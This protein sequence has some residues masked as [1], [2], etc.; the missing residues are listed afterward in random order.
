MFNEILKKF[1]NLQSLTEQEEY[2]LIKE[3][4]IVIHFALKAI[5]KQ[6]LTEIYSQELFE[7]E[8]LNETIIKL[9]DKREIILTKIESSQSLKSYIKFIVVNH[10]KDK[11]KKKTIKLSQMQDS[12]I[13]YES[14]SIKPIVKMEA[15]EFTQISNSN[16]TKKEKEAICLELLRTKQ[17]GYA[18]EKAKSRAKNRLKNIAQEYEFSFD[19][20][21]FA[22]NRLFLS[23]I[24]KEFVSIKEGV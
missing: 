13:E 20:V 12:E 9:I 10:L 1:L 14:P 15:I 21:N 6:S 23:E 17:T 4:K 24:C 2:I 19:A 18:I 5:H 3:I 22:L 16:L 11:I 8:I 7:E